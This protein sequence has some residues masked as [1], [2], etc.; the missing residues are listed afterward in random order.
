[1][2]TLVRLAGGAIAGLLFL[3]H[4]NASSGSGAFVSIHDLSVRDL[5]Q[6]DGFAPTLSVTSA[7]SDVYAS[8]N[9]MSPPFSLVKQVQ[10][11]NL[12]EIVFSINSPDGVSNAFSTVSAGPSGSPGN[13][14]D[15]YAEGVVEASATRIASFLL[16][17]YTEFRISGA[18]HVYGS[19][20]GL[21]HGGEQSAS[22]LAQISIFSDTDASFVDSLDR[23]ATPLPSGERGFYDE[24]RAY[25]F[26]F[27]SGATAATVSI[28]QTASVKAMNVAGVPEPSTFLLLCLGLLLGC[29]KPLAAKLNRP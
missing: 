11:G 9:T 28:Y 8:V 13:Q 14:I 17:P 2:T 3:S 12:E 23:Y 21:A 5:D 16:S 15:T 26:T 7:S 10:Q 27:S 6:D 29:V 24:E 22:S 25:S 1:M 19:S 18:L 20:Q 4:A